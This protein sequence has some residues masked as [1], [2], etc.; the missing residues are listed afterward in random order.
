MIHAYYNDQLISEGTGLNPL[1]AGPLN[2][3]VNEVSKA[4][5]VTIKCD[6]GYKTLGETVITFVGTSADKWSVCATEAGSYQSTLTVSSEITNAG[7][8]VYFKAKATDDESP[9]NDTSVDINIKTV[10]QAV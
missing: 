9:V 7:T 10:I 5:P 1:V 6:E 3:T 8:V 4:I 2:A